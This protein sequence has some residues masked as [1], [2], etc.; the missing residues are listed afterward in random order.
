LQEEVHSEPYS[1]DWGGPGPSALLYLLCA[2]ALVVGAL[3]AV[4]SVRDIANRIGD[5]Q[6][7]P[8][9]GAGQVALDAGRQVVYYEPSAGT[10]TVGQPSKAA[11]ADAIALLDSSGRPLAE[12]GYD[13]NVQMQTPSFDGYAM[14]QV[15]VARAGTY[16][17]RS[18]DAGIPAG[19]VSIGAKIFGDGGRTLIA[20]IIG[21][22][23]ALVGLGG[24]VALFFVRRSKR[25]SPPPRP[26]EIEGPPPPPTEF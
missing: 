3:V 16:S 12:T 1:G 23:I 15:E 21:G 5:L 20:A 13:A 17:V 6:H 4:T 2:A 24:A 10:A 14:F 22:F 7:A 8:F 18:R 26:P 9:P 11:F 25:R 19:R